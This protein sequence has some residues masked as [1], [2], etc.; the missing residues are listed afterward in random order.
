[1]NNMDTYYFTNP[2]D[3]RERAKEVQ[4]KIEMELKDILRLVNPFY[5]QAGNPS[6]E[7]AAL[8]KGEI[9][10]VSSGEIVH[11][12]LKLIRDYKGVI[13]F[14][15]NK[16]SWGSIQEAFFSHYMC[17]KPTYLIFD[18]KT[19][20]QKLGPCKECGTKNPNN[21]TH[22]WPAANST[23]RFISVDAFIKHMREVYNVQ[24]INQK[25]LT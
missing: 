14:I 12:D 1:M 4:R 10:H 5:D 19:S 18:P 3:D 16:S 7:I 2:V 21:I 24:E 17:G 8:D 11:Q 22:P 9:P 6:K 20:A 15:T 25:Q 13:G 23:C